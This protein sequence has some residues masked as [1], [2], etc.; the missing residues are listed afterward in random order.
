[1]N[2]KISRPVE[3]RFLVPCSKDNPVILIISSRTELLALS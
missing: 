3:N 2:K 1:M